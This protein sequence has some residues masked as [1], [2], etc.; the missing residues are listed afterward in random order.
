MAIAQSVTQRRRATFWAGVIAIALLLVIH[1]QTTVAIVGTW[2]NSVTYNHGYLVLPAS[3]WLLWRDRADLS[4]LTL[5]PWW[6]AALGVLAF[7]LLWFIGYLANIK[8]FRDLALVALIPTTLAAVCGR[9]FARQAA[10]PLAFMLFAWPFGEVFIPYLI[11]FTADFT[12]TA[13][14]LSGVPV[15]R[16]GNNFVI[17]S[18]DWSVVQ[19]CSGVRYL[20]VSLFAGALFAYLNFRSNRRRVLFV[21]LALVVPILANWLRAYGIVM[22]GHFSN[23]RFAVGV[24][25]LIY[26]W[27]FFGIVMTALFYF[28]V[29]FMS[30]STSVPPSAP[31]ESGTR[32]RRVSPHLTWLAV[33]VVSTLSAI[34]PLVAARMDAYDIKTDGSASVHF[35]RDLGGWVLGAEL[36]RSWT[37]PFEN[38]SIWE[39]GTYRDLDGSAVTL[40]IA[41]YAADKGPSKLMSFEGATMVDFDAS[42]RVVERKEYWVP[43]VQSPFRV[44]Q[45]IIQSAGTKILVWQWGLIGGIEASGFVDSKLALVRSRL[46]GS[47]SDSTG[48][49]LITAIDDS[50][51]EAAQARLQDFAELLRSR[52]GSVI[53]RG[54]PK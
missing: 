20:L 42:S 28:G 53:E 26:G 40:H 50:N 41:H 45:R 52:I 37:P 30:G 47:G 14:R 29:R 13:L 17:P 21:G 48:I 25:H 4:R 18:G 10:F 44:T 33:A 35:P 5:Q 38:P 7:G 16:E 46:S 8:S 23:N 31:T 39:R 15:F 19:E 6:I 1:W 24:D 2:H 32:T 34:P 12:V 49:T 27:A 3:L 51:V 54:T 11:E 43:A 9:D 36:T 22:L